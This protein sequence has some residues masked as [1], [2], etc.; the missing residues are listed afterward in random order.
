MDRFYSNIWKKWQTPELKQYYWGDDLDLRYYV[1][2][3]FTNIKNK[4][5][6]EIGCGTGIITS[7]LDKSNDITC[8]D[9]SKKSIDIAKKNVPYA[10]F[11]QKRFEDFVTKEKFDLI[12]FTNIIA[13]IPKQTRQSM[14]NKAKNLLKKNGKIILTTVNGDSPY[15]AKIA[16]KPPSDELL[17]YFG[18]MKT[19]IKPWNPFHIHFGKILKYV[20]GIFKIL[21]WMMNKKINFKRSCSYIL[22]ATFPK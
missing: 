20:P 3:L 15:F 2:K 13:V 8:V 1:C 11:V 6:L 18:D 7:F 21:E 9:P 16:I 10:K 4:K 5:I 14:I 19:E 22:T 12:L 17:T